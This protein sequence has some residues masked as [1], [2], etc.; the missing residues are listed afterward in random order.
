MLLR[1]Q[2]GQSQLNPCPH[3]R[4]TRPAAERSLWR[5]TAVGPRLLKGNGA[6]GADQ[7]ALKAPLKTVKA[8]RN[9]RPIPLN[10]TEKNRRVSCSLTRPWKRV[11]VRAHGT[12]PGAPQTIRFH[13]Y[14]R[15]AAGD[16]E[17]DQM[18]HGGTDHRPSDY[19]GRR[20]GRD[21]YRE[22][23]TGTGAPA[24][25]G[26]LLRHR[27]KSSRPT[28]LWSRRKPAANPS[29]RQEGRRVERRRG[30]RGGPA[31]PDH[32]RRPTRTTLRSADSASIVTPGLASETAPCLASRAPPSCVVFPICLRRFS[33]SAAGSLPAALPVHRARGA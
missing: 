9:A 26:S 22:P 11:T 12:A 6:A 7:R 19:Q 18:G 1:T 8:R 23:G 25:A 2:H 16:G 27:W 32:P 15:Q 17:L 30:T 13:G 28:R 21:R 31:R 10:S 5:P 14:C 29:R 3:S 4:L 24:W 20:R 33:I